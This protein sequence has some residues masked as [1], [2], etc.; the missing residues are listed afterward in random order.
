MKKYH[1]KYRPAID[2]LVF[3]SY[4]WRNIKRNSNDR[5]YKNYNISSIGGCAELH[6]QDNEWARNCE[7][8]CHFVIIIPLRLLETPKNSL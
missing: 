6:S 7:G 5:I 1:G 3:I 4:I 8:S 2:F